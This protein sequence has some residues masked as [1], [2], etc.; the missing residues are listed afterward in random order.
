MPCL[1]ELLFY[2]IL[3]KFYRKLKR[4]SAVN[5]GQLEDTDFLIA[6]KDAEV[7][8]LVYSSNVQG[9]LLT[10]ILHYIKL[11]YASN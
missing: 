7:G 2:S 5:L 3:F 10:V 8:L 6:Q 11:I 1:V 4:E 9:H